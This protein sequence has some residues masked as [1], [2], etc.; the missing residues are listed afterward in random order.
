MRQRIF[1]GGA[2]SDGIQTAIYFEGY[3]YLFAGK[4]YLFHPAWPE[5]TPTAPF[6]PSDFPRPGIIIILFGTKLNDPRNFDLS[7]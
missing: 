7:Y 3:P 2:D 6:S 4:R 1:V 5:D